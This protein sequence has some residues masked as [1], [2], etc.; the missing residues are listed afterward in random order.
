MMGALLIHLEASSQS[1]QERATARVRRVSDIDG[2][3]DDSD[4]IDVLVR[5][6]EDLLLE[7]DQGYF[8][9]D[10][11]WRNGKSSRFSSS[12][13]GPD[14]R[15]IELIAPAFVRRTIAQARDFTRPS[16]GGMSSAAQT[17][18]VFASDNHLDTWQFVC[19]RHRIEQQSQLPLASVGVERGEDIKLCAETPDERNWVEYWGG[20]G[21]AI[22]SMP[23][24]PRPE[25]DACLLRSAPEGVPFVGTTN[26]ETAVMVDLIPAGNTESMRT[27]ARKS[28]E[29]L[30][31]P[32]KEDLVR[33][34][35]IEVCAFAYAEYDCF[36]SAPWI[37]L[38]A[39][40]EN[41]ANWL[42][43]LSVILGWRL[44]MQARSDE[45]VTTARRLLELGVRAG[46]PYYA[47]G[48]RL[49]LE[50]LEILSAET[51]EFAQAEK[52]VE[53]VALRT[54]PTEAF[55]TVRP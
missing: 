1:D 35:P 18:E 11:R 28:Y 19:D 27:Y 39:Q 40:I 7:V 55:T 24:S 8:V 43:D 34:R 29:T 26:P 47:M 46:V 41:H 16:A 50:A 22:A 30:S 53:A 10:V 54:V 20:D 9:I 32:Y 6:G 38:L 42:P 13:S 48:V 52:M 51:D 3:P 25:L 44:V 31:M 45:D 17:H 21:W 33:S 36:D 12:V 49:L 23:F 4:G 5:A 15:R 37:D 14:V 2:T